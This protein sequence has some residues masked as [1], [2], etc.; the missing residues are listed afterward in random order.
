MKRALVHASDSIHPEHTGWT[1]YP[2]LGRISNGFAM[3]PVKTSI[4]AS[5]IRFTGSVTAASRQGCRD[6]VYLYQVFC[7][8]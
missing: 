1:V 6:Q 7:F 8:K 4:V 2:G 3:G 5:Y